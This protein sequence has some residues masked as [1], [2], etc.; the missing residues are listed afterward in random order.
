MNTD[1]I[2][3]QDLKVP[4]VVLPWQVD[5]HRQDIQSEHGS[6]SSRIALAS[7]LECMTSAYVENRIVISCVTITYYKQWFS[8]MSREF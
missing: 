3:S 2:Y 8:R 4:V 5:E 7:G 1:K 6:T